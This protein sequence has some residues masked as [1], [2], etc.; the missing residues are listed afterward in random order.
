MN[1]NTKLTVDKT[2]GT[3]IGRNCGSP[4]TMNK[5]GG[6]AGQSQSESTFPV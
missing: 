4:V 2:T 5:D 3:K 6:L 1:Q